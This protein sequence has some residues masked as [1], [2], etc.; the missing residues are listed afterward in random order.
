MLIIG[1]ANSTTAQDHR[2]NVIIIL[3]DDLGYA[4]VGFNGAKDL[5]TP[6]IDNI[7][8]NGVKFTNAY[9]SY[10][11]C[12]PSRAG[13]ITGRHH[14]KFGFCRNPLFAPNDADMG[15]PLSEETLATYLKKSN[16]FTSVIGK[17]HLGAHPSLWPN[18]RGFDHFY[19]FLNGGHRY[20]SKEWDIQNLKGV[21]SQ[22]AAYRTKLLRNEKRLN[23]KGYLTDLLSEEAVKLL[24]PKQ[25]L[26]F[27]VF[28]IQCPHAPMQ[29][30]AKYL[31]RFK[32]VKNKK[33]RIYSAMVSAM[34]DGIGKILQALEETKQLDNTIIFFLSDNGGTDNKER[35]NNAPL[36]GAK[37]DFYE[38]GIR[39][40]FAMMW[41]IKIKKGM[42]YD[43]PII[44]LDIFKTVVEQCSPSIA[45]RNKLDGVNLI[46][47]LT[48][49]KSPHK[50][51]M[52]KDYDLNYEA[53]RTEDL[54]YLKVNN[55]TYVYEINEDIGEKNPITQHPKQKM[56]K[57]EWDAWNKNLAEP[58]FLGL[59]QG[60]KYNKKNP[61]R[62]QI[63]FE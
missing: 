5:P 39:V 49:E 4:D 10:S 19:G 7:G 42:V 13:L 15:L 26:I 53:L 58:L 35:L 36:K 3:A 12:G 52:W 54:K 55:Q 16:Y 43:K 23:E 50:M 20:F 1:F 45:S 17:W 18:K 2:P 34:D 24:K 56:L 11:R 9:E 46:P 38:G 33:R 29:A 22:Y 40:P 47:F 57:N 63:Q 27:H 31:K 59:P 51:I 60:K 14:D 8:N 61:N 25:K 37:G 6:N 21:K 32:H 44:S 28:G 30:T 48:N 41:P 62:F